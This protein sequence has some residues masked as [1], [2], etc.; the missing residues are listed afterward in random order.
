MKLFRQNTRPIVVKV[1]ICIGLSYK[2]NQLKIMVKIVD[3]NRWVASFSISFNNF[4]INDENVRHNIYFLFYNYSTDI[5]FIYLLDD[6][7]FFT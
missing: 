2:T 1:L 3:E 7:I 6:Y 4:Q 5:V